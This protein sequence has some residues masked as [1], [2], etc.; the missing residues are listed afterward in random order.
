MSNYKGSMFGWPEARSVLALLGA[1]LWFGTAHAASMSQK[2]VQIIAKAIGFMEPAPSG[3]GT[4]AIVYNA[5]DSASKQ[6]AE[7]V[8][9]Y[10][11]DG[12]KAGNA[13]LKPKV[14]AVGELGAGGFLAIIAPGTTMND[15][16]SAASRAQ[17][18]LC[19]TTDDA[20]VHSGACAM[21]VKSEPKV[22]I[23][24]SR[25]AATAA[26]VGFGS[27]FLLMAHQI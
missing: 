12:L 6:D 3:A 11:G 8:A 1:C 26:G 4:V 25:S 7:A 22:E 14:V 16:V 21:S 5:S 27:A 17:H 23:T 13:V 19:I 24:I 20:A 10:F 2:D 9:A 18:A 15:Q